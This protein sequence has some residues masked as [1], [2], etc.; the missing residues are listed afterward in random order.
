MLDYGNELYS[1]TS[2]SFVGKSVAAVLKKP[3]ETAN[4]YLTVASFTTSQRDVLRI[5]E[6]EMGVRTLV[7]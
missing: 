6:D 1:P 4:K 3:A 5:I 2:L 7:Y